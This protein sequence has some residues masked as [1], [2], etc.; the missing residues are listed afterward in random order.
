MTIRRHAD[1]SALTRRLTPR[2]VAQLWF[3]RS[4]AW[5]RDIHAEHPDFPL[6]GPD[7]LY[8]AAQVEEWFDRWHGR[9]QSDAGFDRSAEEE[10]MRIARS[11]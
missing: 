1:I 5:A 8:L 6:P 2:E 4:A 7:G 9:R 3:R 10:A 11:A